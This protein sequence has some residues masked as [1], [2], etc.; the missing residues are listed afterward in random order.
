MKKIIIAAI[1]F[2]IFSSANCSLAQSGGEK[3]MDGLE[4]AAGWGYSNSSRPGSD[5]IEDVPLTIGTMVGYVLSFV[6]I[7]FLVLMIYAGFLWMLAG[8]NDQQV[9]KAK[10]LIGA[11]VIGLIIVLAAYAF[12]TLLGDMLTK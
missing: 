11:A 6:G 2:V 3:A 8:G 7:L 9:Q 1:L 5:V 10:S 12:T 4:T